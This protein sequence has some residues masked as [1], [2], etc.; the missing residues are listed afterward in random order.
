MGVLK[1]AR[2]ALN[3][4]I[5]GIASDA[6]ADGY[7][8]GRIAQSVDA[9]HFR[10]TRLFACPRFRSAVLTV[11]AII[12]RCAL[13]CSWLDDTI[14]ERRQ[15]VSVFDWTHATAT[16]VNDEAT[17]K[18]AHATARLVN[19]VA[20]FNATRFA[21]AVNIQRSTRWAHTIAIYVTNVALV[22]TAQ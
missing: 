3:F 7:V 22:H 17:F 14:A 15:F 21:F 2:T 8:S 1:V 9:T 13:C 12:V 5:A 10:Q 20:V 4:W 18:G 11:A 16:L 6:L 19:F